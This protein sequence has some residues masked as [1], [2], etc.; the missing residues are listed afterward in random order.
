MAFTLLTQLENFSL[1]FSLV[2]VLADVV[3]LLK[4]RFVMAN[5]SFVF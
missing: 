2:E 1:S 5:P 3:V 4:L